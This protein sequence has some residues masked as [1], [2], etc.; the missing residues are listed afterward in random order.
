MHA[1]DDACDEV[2]FDVRELGATVGERAAQF[3]LLLQLCGL[4]DDAAPSVLPADTDDASCLFRWETCDT[5]VECLTNPLAL[6]PPPSPLHDNLFSF[7]PPIACF[8]SLT[9]VLVESRAGSA[10][11]LAVAAFVA[12]RQRFHACSTPAS[13]PA[14]LWCAAALAHASIGA[15]AAADLGAVEISSFGQE[16]A[17]EGAQHALSWQS[18]IYGECGMEGLQTLLCLLE[19]H[20]ALQLAD[21]DGSV[22]G[23]ADADADAAEGL[24][25]RRRERNN[26]LTFADLGHGTG[27][28]LLS[29]L[30]LRPWRRVCGVELC[31]KR[32]AE[33]QVY[34]LWL[35]ALWLHSLWLYPLWFYYGDLTL[36]GSSHYGSTYYGST[37]YGQLLLSRWRCAARGGKGC[38]RRRGSEGDEGGEGSGEGGVGGEGGEGA[39]LGE[40]PEADGAQG[41]DSR[42][43]ER[44]RDEGRRRLDTEVSVA[45][46]DACDLGRLGFM[47]RRRPARQDTP[48]EA[49]GRPALDLTLV[50][51]AGG[52]LEEALAPVS[53]I[54]STGWG[55]AV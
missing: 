48:A 16:G 35:H 22:A 46:G 9:T 8:N 38:K 32:F 54:G 28:L 7:E 43:S 41:R 1:V 11:A 53:H 37:Y 13:P 10:C 6:P 25:S 31:T 18:C 4:T 14:P 42:G 30:L 50:G 47:W 52:Q 40:H 23:A 36:H 2:T 45:C 26:G 3:A 21:A 19:R 29:A 34:L 44:E 49:G 51:R 12:D 17:Q 55:L 39:L 5:R 20:C 33:S 24:A 27:A 15:R